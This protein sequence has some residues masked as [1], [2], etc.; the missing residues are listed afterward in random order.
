MLSIVWK[1]AAREDL[2]NIIQ[3]IA[4]E[5][6]AAARKLKERIETALLPTSEHPYIYP[7]SDRMPDF[8]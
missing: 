2:L 4:A 5:N 7:V 1:A 8:L 3:Y 6:P